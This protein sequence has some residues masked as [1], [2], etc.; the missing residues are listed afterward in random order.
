[1]SLKFL[2]RAKPKSI[3]IGYKSRANNLILVFFTDTKKK[4][5]Y[6]YMKMYMYAVQ[7]SLPIGK[8]GDAVILLWLFLVAS[9]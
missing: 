6:A 8:F 9:P 5:S 4:N 2:L 3:I 1:M 7:L